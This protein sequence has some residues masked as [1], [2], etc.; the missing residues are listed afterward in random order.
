MQM[1]DW[2]CEDS[3]D[4]AICVFLSMG[5]RT[6]NRGDVGNHDSTTCPLALISSPIHFILYEYPLHRCLSPSRE[7]ALVHGRISVRGQEDIHIVYTVCIPWIFNNRKLYLC[8]E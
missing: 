1:S 3:G 8:N 6:R 7:E 5:S 2:V 4:R